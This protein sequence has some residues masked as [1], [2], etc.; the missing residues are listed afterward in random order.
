MH[1]QIPQ[2]VLAYALA[3]L[4]MCAPRAVRAEPYVIGFSGAP[5]TQSC[6]SSCHGE[7]SGSVEIHGFPE[8][9]VPDSLYLIQVASTGLLI[10]NFNASCRIGDGTQEAGVLSGTGVTESYSVTGELNGI[11]LSEFDQDTVEFIWQAPTHGSGEVRL[12][13]A[14]HQGH[15]TGPNNDLMLVATEQIIPQP[16]DVPHHPYPADSAVNVPINLTLTWDEVARADSFRVFFGL[17]SLPPLAATQR[18]LQFTLPQLLPATRYYW[19]IEAFNSVGTTSGPRWS[20][21]T[22]PL[23]HS[24]SEVPLDFKFHSPYPNPFNH[25]TTFSLELYSPQYLVITVVNMLGQTVSTLH[26]GAMNTG[27]HHLSWTPDGATGLYFLSIRA[28][29][30]HQLHKVLYLK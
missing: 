5:G 23:S 27:T 25:S 18:L 16:P 19:R 15:D 30:S 12:Y 11:H 3:A 9:Y 29:R 14:A 17:D 28:E 22:E 6:A 26:T 21:V 2:I 20:F 1:D 10:K 24:I 4:L 8:A 7:G 13:L